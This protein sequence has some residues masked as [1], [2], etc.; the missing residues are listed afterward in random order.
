VRNSQGFGLEDL[1]VFVL[2]EADRLLEMGFKEEVKRC[3]VP[4]MLLSA[5]SLLAVCLLYDITRWLYLAGC[6]HSVTLP[7]LRLLLAKFTNSTCL[8]CFPVDFSASG[9]MTALFCL[10]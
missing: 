4:A 8:L 7:C 10:F 3:Y 5:C 9:S 6:I 2:D 1:A